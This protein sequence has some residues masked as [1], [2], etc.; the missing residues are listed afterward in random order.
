MIATFQFFSHN[1]SNYKPNQIWRV[2]HYST[3]SHLT[4]KFD[5]VKTKENYEYEIKI[6]LLNYL[7]IYF[8]LQTNV[9]L[10]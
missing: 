9:F 1:L 5:H 7:F 8:S 4:L 6:M 2:R 10:V 3:F